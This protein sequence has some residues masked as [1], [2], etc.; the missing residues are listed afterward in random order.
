MRFVLIAMVLL[1]AAVAAVN[2]DDITRLKGCINEKCPSEYSKCLGKSGCEDKLESC[3]YK[4]DIKVDTLCWGGC[5]G[6][7][8]TV[9]INACTCAVN[10]G[11]LDNSSATSFDRT[12]LSLMKVIQQYGDN[13]RQAEQ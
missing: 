7:F 11:C 6:I 9:A 5:L 10:Q 3:A 12:V 13:L 1:V 8:N 2:P 4:C